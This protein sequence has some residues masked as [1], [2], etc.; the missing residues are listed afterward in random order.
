VHVLNLYLI[1][2]GALTATLGWG[3][4]GMAASRAAWVATGVPALLLAGIT[5]FAVLAGSNEA[6]FPK[7]ESEFVAVWSFGAVAAILG[8]VAASMGAWGVASDLAFGF[9]AFFFAAA[10]GLST[11]A[12]AA[13][14]SG[15]F[16]ILALGMLIAAVTG[17]LVF[18][19]AA[20]V[21]GARGLRSVLGWLLVVAGIC[22]AFLGY[23]P[24][25]H[26]QF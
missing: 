18:L 5:I 14:A 20:L 19:S 3:W 4:A 22:V 16:N 7:G 10:G 23:A 13:A 26:V 12:Y 6:A 1:L 17:L 24:L 11:A 25:I 15:G 9:Y 2:V 8:G 21:P